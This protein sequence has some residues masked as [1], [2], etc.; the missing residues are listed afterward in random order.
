MTLDAAL[1]EALM[2]LSGTAVMTP[3]D[4][5]VTVKGAIAVDGIGPH[6][7]TL[8]PLLIERVDAGPMLAA[9]LDK[10][11]AAA[12]VLFEIAFARS[13]GASRVEISDVV[14]LSVESTPRE[15]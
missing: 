13:Y 9:Y 6:D 7:R 3:S 1:R 10:E 15:L 5:R 2:R 8:G 11:F 14:R 4:L 12:A